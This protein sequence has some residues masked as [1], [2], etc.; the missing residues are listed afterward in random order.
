MATSSFNTVV[1][2]D[3][4]S[5]KSLLDI[6]EKESFKYVDLNTNIEVKKVSLKDVLDYIPKKSKKK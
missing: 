3:T 6:M 4:N 1:K 5:I 2:I